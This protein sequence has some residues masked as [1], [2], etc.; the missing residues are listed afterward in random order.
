MSRAEKIN[1]IINEYKS[2]AEKMRWKNDL[3]EEIYDILLTLEKS[4][5]RFIDDS[6]SNLNLFSTLGDSLNILREHLQELRKIEKRFSKDTVSVGVIG[7]ARQGKSRLLQSITGLNEDVIPA[8]KG[9]FCTGSRIRI[10]NDPGES[11]FEVEFYSEED[12]LQI[13][14]AYYE[15]LG[16]GESPS[17]IQEFDSKTIPIKEFKGS[18][19][20][21]IYKKLQDY[22]NNLMSYRPRLGKGI[23]QIAQEEIWNFAA[24]KNQQGENIYNYLA[25]REVR[26]YCHLQNF[27]STEK[28]SVIDLP[29]MGETE[30]SVEKRLISALEEDADF[31][32]F[33]CRPD[34]Y[35]SA[36]VDKDLELYDLVSKHFGQQLD[37]RSFI[38]LNRTQKGDDNYLMCQ[39][40][41]RT[42]KSNNMD[43][44]DSKII[45]CSNHEESI[46]V[47]NEIVDYLQNN[48]ES[49]N[50]EYLTNFNNELHSAYSLVGKLLEELDNKVKNLENFDD[51]PLFATLF[52]TLFSKISGSLEELARK[53]EK[54]MSEDPEFTK[55]IIQIIE[56]NNAINVVPDV[57]AIKTIYSLD[58]RQSY[59]ITYFQSLIYVRN[60]LLESLRPI[61]EEFQK[62][63]LKAKEEVAHVLNES[64][65]GVFDQE[66]EAFEGLNFLKNL[67]QEIEQAKT[68][69]RSPAIFDKLSVELKRLIDYDIAPS[70]VVEQKLNEH[71]LL[72]DP[73]E[74]DF[75]TKWN[76]KEVA[77]SLIEYVGKNKEEGLP[78]PSNKPTSQ[79]IKK[80]LVS[81][82]SLPDTNT[83][84]DI[85]KL[86]FSD[87][88]FGDVS[89]TI[90]ALLRYVTSASTANGIDSEVIAGVIQGLNTIYK[91]EVLTFD[92]IHRILYQRYT[93][94]FE[95]C[96]ETLRE[97]C[98]QPSQFAYTM[99]GE[100]VQKVSRERATEQA[101]RAFLRVHHARVWPSEFGRYREVIE[102]KSQW[103]NVLHQA[104]SRYNKL[105]EPIS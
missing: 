74:N 82:I 99:V 54:Q 59:K 64:G 63:L 40:M 100:F 32:L 18:K 94:V 29:G 83:F 105:V 95:K 35:S 10:I 23:K 58:G 67:L 68:R 25:V 34:S 92:F 33:L 70:G 78:E 45:D 93:L 104:R 24:H 46:L 69:T 44:L 17:N 52:D 90:N 80:T 76:L 6:D 39:E 62:L 55:K 31:V 42:I 20:Q 84:V 57:S 103:S 48:I 2:Q 49:L 21:T 14:K 47:L 88:D 12:V 86:I 97:L 7:R 101:W 19:E 79:D 60:K 8:R 87:S 27:D 41:E 15:G 66:S 102:Y 56:N 85:S 81:K 98:Q 28:V 1:Q 9:D 89:A 26:I 71:L 51:E 43:Y 5:S 3:V 30:L 4:S 96:K 11:K 38:I 37:R 65:L 61:D 22:K 36:W 77:I 13:I 73:D 16:L 53:L 50:H 75:P 91:N 72:L